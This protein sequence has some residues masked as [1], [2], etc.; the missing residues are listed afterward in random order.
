[1]LGILGT[2]DAPLAA[3]VRY[4]SN[5]GDYPWHA[6]LRTPIGPVLVILQDRHDLLT[7]N[8]IF[9][10]R[11]YGPGLHGTVVDI[12]ANVGF[13][14]LFFLTRT[15]DARVWAYEPDPANA[16]RLRGVLS[17]HEDRYTLIEAAVTAVEMPSVRFVPAGRYGH[18]ASVDEPGID[19]PAISI[20]QALR[21]VVRDAG[22]ID[23]VKIDTEGTD[24][25]LATAVPLQLPV[26]EIRY[27]DNRGRVTILR[28]G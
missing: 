25:E 1:L 20:A 10:R 22:A 5:R 15:R 3:L 24:E 18:L 17:G 8:E 6:I 11:D 23:L 26:K 16:L 13:A 21:D 7:V 14:S 27:E 12:G 2:F 28:R 4:L 9:C 19:V